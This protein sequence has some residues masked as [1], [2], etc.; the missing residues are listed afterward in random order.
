MKKSGFI[1][2]CLVAICLSNTVLAIESGKDSQALVTKCENEAM[3][4]GIEDLVEMDNYVRD[5]KSANSKN[6]NSM[7]SKPMAKDFINSVESE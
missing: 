1:L 7:K 4:L 2:C 3:T 5:C 6:A